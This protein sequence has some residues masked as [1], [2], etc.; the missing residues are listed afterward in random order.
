MTQSLSCSIIAVHS[1]LLFAFKLRTAF[2][3]VSQILFASGRWR[4]TLENTT[5][6]L[7]WFHEIIRKEEIMSNYALRIPNSLMDLAKEVAKKE[8][9]SL[10]QLFLTGLKG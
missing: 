7:A 3:I 2:G 5:L 10:N 4:P 8:N 6:F 9:T 1:F